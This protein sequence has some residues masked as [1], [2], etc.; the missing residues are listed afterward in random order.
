MSRKSAF[1]AFVL[2]LVLSSMFVLLFLLSFAAYGGKINVP[3]DY[4][5]IQAAINAAMSGDTINVSSGLYYENV[6]VNKTLTLIG[7]G[8]SSTIID[9]SGTGVVVT[10]V[11][12]YV[13]ISGFTIRNGGK[14]G[15]RIDIFGH[16]N[17]RDN[18][19][20]DNG[21]NGV[22]LRYSDDNA[23]NSNYVTDNGWSDL[24]YSG[25]YVESCWGNTIIGNTIT[26]EAPSADGIHFVDSHNN[27]IISNT[28]TLCSRYGVFSEYSDNN[29]FSGNNA[30]S[31][32][33][34]GI[35][36]WS[37]ENSTV[38]GNNASNNGEYGISVSNNST[39]SDNNVNDNEY[40]GIVVG[41]RNI[42]S[43]NTIKNNTYYGISAGSDNIISGN[44]VSTTLYGIWLSANNSVHH[45]NF[46][47][48]TYQVRVDFVLANT[49]D[50]GY[51]S[52]GNHWSD[53][54]GVDLYCGPYQNEAGSDGFGDTPYM[55]DS[56]NQD[57]YPLMSP[58]PWPIK[59]LD[60]GMC[61]L[62]IQRAIYDANTLDGHTIFVSAGIYNERVVVN[63]SLTIMGDGSTTII[64][65]NE[66]GT[67]ITI[68][69]DSVTLS[70]FTIRNSGS[71][72]ED[73]GI[74]LSSNCTVVGNIITNNTNGI[75]SWEN[76]NNTVVDNTISN[77]QRGTWLRNSIRCNISDNTMSNN[78]EGVYLELSNSNSIG[79]NTVTFNDFGLRLN[80]SD[81]NVIRENTVT[82]SILGIGL[83][84]S[85]SNTLE[86]NNV[87]SG[88]SQGIRLDHSGG[89]ILRGNNISDNDYN[90]AIC[91]E[92]LSD[93]MQD[94]DASNTVDGRPI[95][96]WVN[97]SNKQ[98]TTDVGYVAIVNSTRITVRDLNLTKNGQGVLFV[99][100]TNS[101]IENVNAT[102]NF[103][104]IRLRWSNNN[105]IVYNTIGNN[106]YG[107]H[108]NYSDNNV[109]HHNNFVNNVNQAYCNVSNN[110]WDD[111][112]P[113]GGNY[114]SDYAGTDAYSG[115]L[116]N[117]PGGDDLGD[118]P[119]VIDDNNKD[120]YPLMGPWPWPVKNLDT[121]IRY[122]TI[123]RAIYASGTLNGHTIFA[124]SGTYYEQVVV[125]KS[126][127]LLG[128][129]RDTTTVKFSGIGNCVAIT[130]D[131]ATFCNFTVEGTGTGAG[132]YIA[133]R[134]NV[135]VRDAAV[136]GFQH[137]I[138]ITNSANCTVSSIN[139]INNGRGI[140]VCFSENITVFG[141]NVTS[142]TYYGI[143]L[144]ELSHNNTV[145]GN[146]ITNNEWGLHL[147][148]SCNNTASGNVITSNSGDGIYI[149][150]LSDNNT[151]I[152]NTISSNTGCGIYFWVSCNNTVNGNTIT[153][154]EYGIYVFYYSHRNSF[155]GNTI[156]SSVS[157]G[158]YVQDSQ[159]NIFTGNTIANNY[160]HGVNLKS[161]NNAIYHNNFIG[162]T[163]QARSSGS[164][165]T[166]DDGYPS[167]GNYWSN[168]GGVDLYKGPYQ[169]ETGRDCIGDTPYVIDGS[170][171]DKYPF[172]NRWR[173]PK[174][175]TAYFTY[176]P[177]R[178]VE[179]ETIT[180]NASTSVI[181]WNGTHATSIINYT[182]NFGDNTSTITEED[183]V[184]THNYIMVET[185]TVTLNITDSQ[186][187]WGTVSK[188]VRTIYPHDLAIINVTSAK[189]VV[190]QGYNCNINITLE[191][192]G[193]FTE[194]FNVT[195]YAATTPIASQNV[196]LTSDNSTII[197]L[198]WNTTGFTKGN[199]TIW[200]Y[201]W[202]VLG[203]THIADN[204]CT[205]ST[206]RIGVLGD[207]NGDSK[208]GPYDF[209]VFA[210]A[211]G[212]T[213]IMTNWN[214]NCDFDNSDKVGP[215]DFF[216]FAR[217]YGKTES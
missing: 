123:Q 150:T 59:N 138:Y 41:S 122:L 98:V 21:W 205:G 92:S 81:Y 68:T 215:Y 13:N 175:P 211:Y 161:S 65:G 130:A 188:T 208:V 168:Y 197:T 144:D 82:N 66:I 212:S 14:D 45:N 149:D 169:N 47:S 95:C 193:N 170:N 93:F 91:G 118:T 109:A 178:P 72:L 12:D 69:K 50:D 107:I 24:F 31:N 77:N 86:D 75:L 132:I 189:T 42:V 28:I 38:S 179:D 152:D 48:N 185:Y 192:R 29:V 121:G 165:N 3:S 55:I 23:I 26:S 116:Q 201:A 104:G 174:A 141:N 78:Q 166:W 182:W 39:V 11:A 80:E 94:V 158:I 163:Q 148:H 8:P 5:T 33:S 99:H 180:F 120:N 198:T 53:Y 143:D 1:L 171:R 126:I 32:G 113:S 187:L 2:M 214:P 100:V 186:G 117:E 85:G 89:N 125:N 15:I 63:K 159:Y 18:N 25:V 16:S 43:G 64:D 83:Y 56:N 124:S 217:N 54:M 112:Y 97:Q 40:G 172:M 49:W 135:T 27:T 88:S 164:T 74:S 52:G 61:Y 196:T 73:S 176:S 10:V 19:I 110:V 51:P 22:C 190:G 115:P 60:T 34:Q 202:P 194:T 134:N 204:N 137:G 105:T 151:I 9:G 17:I 111:G 147:Y 203:E 140:Y 102:N 101:T 207:L 106:E 128:E 46:I 129:E 103:E 79:G 206:V 142:N 213:P 90:F 195:A 157:D 131:D 145:M 139:A 133:D 209:Y 181:G 160:L 67:V 70:G 108:V 184:V 167:G 96:Y 155:N 62:I 35:Y 84:D 37:S 114:W 153:N 177:L 146:T 200:A 173:V 30:T 57:N 76:S 216:L 136:I 20:T 191:N 7:A 6:V 44:N 36:L 87:T 71:S 162:N 58:W 199:Y 154:N 210:R 119:Y 183:P 156:A 127:T 4:P